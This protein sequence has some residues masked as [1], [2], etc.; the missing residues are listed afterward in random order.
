MLSDISKVFDGLGT[1]SPVT[2]KSKILMQELWRLAI[3]W[4]EPISSEL[5]NEFLSYR[6]NLVKL[7]DF[8]ISRVY[9]P[10]K[11]I[12]L[13][14]LIG[15]SDASTRA[16][17][18]VVYLRFITSTGNVM[19]SFVR[20]K[21]RIAPLKAINIHRLELLGSGGAVLLSK[22]INQVCTDMNLPRSHV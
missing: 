6:S 8:S 9:C 20:A 4:D 10:T 3:S 17:S 21:I 13:K 1:L 12:A 2:I 19:T 5:E 22:L 16:Y 11:T 7:V 14:C 15:F 18:A